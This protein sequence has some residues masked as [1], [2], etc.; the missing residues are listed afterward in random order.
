MK[1]QIPFSSENKKNNITLSSVESAQRVVKVNDAVCS[2][3]ILLL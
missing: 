2:R 1:C 3:L